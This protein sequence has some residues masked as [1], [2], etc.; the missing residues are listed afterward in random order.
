M[1]FIKLFKE[2][3]INS[4]SG[5][6]E[7]SSVKYMFKI[8]KNIDFG[9]YHEY[10]VLR[11]LKTLPVCFDNFPNVH[12]LLKKNVRKNF[13]D[14][15][16]PLLKS[17]INSENII[18]ECLLIEYIEGETLYNMLDHLSKSA[19]NSIVSRIFLALHVA[20]EIT[21][22]CHYDMHLSNI[23]LKRTDDKVLYYNFKDGSS[24]E[25]PT[26]GFIPVIVDFGLS[27][28]QNILNKNMGACLNFTNVGC[29]SIQKNKV[30]DLRFFMNIISNFMD[31]D[32]KRFISWTER[33][34]I[35]LSAMDYVLYALNDF[36]GSF[37]M[38]SN[39]NGC[40]N[41]FKYLIKPPLKYNS[42]IDIKKN[43]TQ[44]SNEIKKIEDISN[45]NITNMHILKVIVESIAMGS[46]SG[47]SQEEKKKII[48]YIASFGKF[49][50]PKKLNLDKL[51]ESISN[52]ALCIEGILYVAMDHTMNEIRAEEKILSDVDNLDI[53]KYFY[54]KI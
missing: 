50:L 38:T 43:Y 27:Y 3:G 10:H 34:S 39:K 35:Q 37:I 36:E 46:G 54:N 17:K 42:Y 52:I 13:Y 4:I 7:S 30:S 20:Q 26:F 49:H 28:S 45:C 44:I 41:L 8:S 24:I 18:T 51:Y 2:Q 6:V 1:K 12:S 14:C 9:I 16:N 48:E 47:F 40:I 31:D 25:I 32:I 53:C 15:P 29:L 5:I 19:L 21:G 23:I 11:D 22:F 33:P